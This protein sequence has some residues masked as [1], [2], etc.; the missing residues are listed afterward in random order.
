M[1]TKTA[2]PGGINTTKEAGGYLRISKQHVERLIRA[3]EIDASKVGKFWR[4]KQ[5]SL[6]AYLAKCQT[7]GTGKK[8]ISEGVLAKLKFNAG[9]RVSTIGPKLI[10]RYDAD[11]QNLKATIIESEPLARVPKIAKL[12]SV[13]ETREAKKQ[14]LGNMPALLNQLSET[15]YPGMME[16][17]GEDPEDLEAQ[18]VAIAN[19]ALNVQGQE[20]VADPMNQY[21]K[22]S[23]GTNVPAAQ[24]ATVKAKTAASE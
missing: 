21:L 13:V 22:D 23:L 15:A 19:D 2:A 5:S 12:K 6:D 3:G 20:K 16:L 14:K 24:K 4:I 9:L 11:A 10:E 17:A 7:N 8:T 18:F 1:N